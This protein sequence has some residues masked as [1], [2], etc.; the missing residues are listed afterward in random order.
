MARKPV[1][2]DEVP[3]DET[4]FTVRDVKRLMVL[5]APVRQ[6]TPLGLIGTYCLCGT[7]VATWPSHVDEI[8]AQDT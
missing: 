2:P 3:G 4:V 5:H 7:R 1:R 8:L 6:V